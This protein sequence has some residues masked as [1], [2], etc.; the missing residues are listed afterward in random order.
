[1]KHLTETISSTGSGLKKALQRLEDSIVSFSAI[2]DI[3]VTF[4]SKEGTVL[5]EYG[6]E[7]KFCLAN[8]E[9]YHQD[10]SCM[11]NL[12]FAMKTAHSIGDVYIYVCNTGLINMCYAFVHDGELIGYFNAGPVAMG[13]NRA[14]TIGQFYEKV[15]QEK[16]NL[17]KLMPLTGDMQVRTPKEVTYLYNLYL[18]AM[19]S[20]FMAGNEQSVTRR[21]FAEQ[22]EIGTKIIEMKK[23]KIEMKYPLMQE[24][25]FM[26]SIKNGDERMSRRL[27]SEYLGELMVFEGGNLSVI[28]MRLLTLFAKVMNYEND[29][30]RDYRSLSQMEAINNAGTFAE[31][32][33]NANSIIE[34]I[35]G[36]VA[37]K[38]YSGDSEIIQRALDYIRQNY[39][40]DISLAKIAGAI[41]VNRTY[42]STLFKK[43]MGSSLVEHINELRLTA[44]AEELVS[45]NASITDIAISCGFKELS[46]FTKLFKEK[47]GKTPRRFRNEG[48]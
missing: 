35:T 17:S 7:K 44:A 11:M 4:F 34:V 10:S 9:Y 43:E 12:K 41:H 29:G 3:P 31:L 15:R 36:D 33:G 45:G 2:A 30:V 40:D 38:T 13:K 18:N 14:R 39:R 20:P 6:E 19:R 8:E 22:S 47:Y 24:Q 42:L 1:M 32:S 26:Q 23:S 28:K 46:Y 48:K 37:R 5:W 27:F 16:I 21:Q 25:E